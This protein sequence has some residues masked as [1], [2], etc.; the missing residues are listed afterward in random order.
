MDLISL[1]S[2]YYIVLVN[3]GVL[4]RGYGVFLLLIRLDVHIYANTKSAQQGCYIQQ[5][6]LTGNE[7]VP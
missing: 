3:G 4:H 2:L 7:T 1:L 5:F 6:S